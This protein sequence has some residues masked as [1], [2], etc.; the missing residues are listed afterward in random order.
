MSA[1]AGYGKSTLIS[2]WLE[3]C[4][5]PNAWISLDTNDSDLRSFIIYF[6]EAIE[7]MFPGSAPESRRLLKATDLPPMDVLSA[8]MINELYGIDRNFLLVLDDYHSIRNKDVHELLGQLLIHP[9]ET[10]HLV[11]VTRRD[12]PFPLFDLRAR[13]R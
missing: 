4:D 13:A 1:P 5:C 7:T 12:P 6:I 9:P 2:C 8:N 10:M 3:S 11:V